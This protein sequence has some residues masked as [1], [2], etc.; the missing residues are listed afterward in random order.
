M[1]K[2]AL[3]RL[4]S[5]LCALAI[6]SGCGNGGSALT[7]RQE[8]AENVAPAV[9]AATD[10][11]PG[12]PQLPFGDSDRPGA[13]KV[14]LADNVQTGDQFFSRGGSATVNGTALELFSGGAGDVTWGMW[15]WSGF[16]GG[17]IPL[18]LTLDWVVDPG[19]EAWLLTSNYTTGLWQINGPLD[20][21]GSS[22][23]YGGAD[24]FIS[25]NGN[26]Y[27]AIITT[28]G[29]HT[30]VN[31]LNVT[32]D[33]DILGPCKPT[34]LHTTNVTSFGINLAW[35]ECEDSRNN[36]YMLTGGPGYDFSPGEPGVE[37]LNSNP[38]SNPTYNA[39]GL[40]P[41]ETYHFRIEPVDPVS[42]LTGPLSDR[43]TVTTIP[44]NPPTTP[45][46]LH[47]TTV[48][49]TSVTLAWDASTDDG[50]V[51]SYNL[52]SGPAPNFDIATQ[53]TLEAS[54]ISGTSHTVGGL[55]ITTTYH[56]RCV[57]RDLANQQSPAS[58]TCT[59][60]TITNQPPVPDFYT[61]PAYIEVGELTFFDP[62]PSTDDQSALVDCIAD[63]DFDSD[64]TFELTG[65]PGNQLQQFTFSTGGDVDVTLRLW[66]E[67]GD[68]GETTKT[69]HVNGQVDTYNL[70]VGHGFAGTVLGADAE[71]SASRFAVAVQ[72]GEAKYLYIYNG[73]SWSSVDLGAQIGTDFVGDV[74]I[75]PSGVVGVLH[76]AVPNWTISEYDGSSWSSGG[77]GTATGAAG[78]GS[79][80]LAYSPGNGRYAAALMYPVPSGTATN[81]WDMV[82][83][84]QT[85]AGSNNVQLINN[86]QQNNALDLVRNDASTYCVYT[87]NDAG[88][89]VRVATVNDGSNSSSSFQTAAS[90]VTQL[91]IQKDPSN[92]AQVFW[93]G[94]YGA[95]LFW[96]DNY[97]GANGGGQTFAT[98]HSSVITLLGNKLIDDNDGAVYFVSRD[99]VGKDYLRGYQTSTASLWEL[100]SAQG[101]ADSGT[102]AYFGSGE[103][104]FAT[105]EDRDGAVH[106]YTYND[107]TL[108]TDEL[109]HQPLSQA[110]YG[111][112]NAA[113]AFADGSLLGFINEAYPDT[114]RVDGANADSALTGQSAGFDGWALPYDACATSDADL[115][116]LVSTT[117]EDNLVL[118]TF[119]QSTGETVETLSVGSVMPGTGRL[120]YSP[121]NGKACLTYVAS[122]DDVTART[123]NGAAWSAPVTV[124]N[125]STST[126]NIQVAA[127]P[128]GEFGIAFY[129]TN[130]SLRF[131]ESSGGGSAWG[132]AGEISNSTL[133]YFC[134][135]GMDYD[136]AGTCY[137]AVERDSV[138]D[139]LW[140][141]TIPDGGSVAW[142]QTVPTFGT[143]AASIEV[144]ARSSGVDILYYD[145]SGGSLTI[146]GKVKRVYQIGGSWTSVLLPF[147][148][149]G[150]PF[151]SA[152]DA[153]ENILLCGINYSVNPAPALAAVLHAE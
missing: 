16:T 75:A 124:Y 90:R 55:S 20:G 69:L 150:A 140:L 80:A 131:A 96:G 134:G 24:S 141:G 36:I 142:E 77:S 74:A 2:R 47:T 34:N 84:H 59:F 27:V 10:I 21:S 149:H 119:S 102:G 66:D 9:P 23:P 122:M 7:S 114:L 88:T 56:F 147:F 143:V 89:D 99:A 46:N 33:Q 152:M 107:S 117:D 139:G 116:M 53:G 41:G 113:V 25:P 72:A 144:F 43:L 85:G 146:Q 148:M 49:G 151:G 120:A 70:G 93:S 106:G 26:T 76:H 50:G 3:S 108:G 38:R 39:T 125:G 13:V 17:I 91:L 82:V 68:F 6:A 63:W 12:L 18:D 29:D 19:T 73:S 14:T 35:D 4:T 129:D 83:F 15:R 153:S 98:G 103:V 112:T 62:S 48:G 42:T 44:D 45:G 92:S 52:Y 1:T 135:I 32:A 145:T 121:D 115:A 57:A 95:T 126:S 136:S 78:F 31:S 118:C 71:P 30:T 109:I 105:T 110:S 130:F 132:A 86:F 81:I 111:G 40:S 8:P 101:L 100:K 22:F 104:Y 123:W 5:T 67:D 87:G 54:G 60:T 94:R 11:F 28:D 37:K 97:G 133:S 138:G 51:V 64:G 79:T 61:S 127:K 58:N 137:I 65:E 128:G